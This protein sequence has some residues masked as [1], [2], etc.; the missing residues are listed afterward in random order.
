M[1]Y[2]EE[3]YAPKT[4]VQDFSEPETLVEEP[5]DFA[6]IEDESDISNDLSGTFDEDINLKETL[7]LSEPNIDVA[8]VDEPESLSLSALEDEDDLQSSDAIPE[9][10]QASALFSA[11]IK[12]TPTHESTATA[13]KSIADFLPD[14]KD[15]F[16]SQTQIDDFENEPVLFPDNNEP[17]FAERMDEPKEEVMPSEPAKTKFIDKILGISRARKNRKDTPTNDDRYTEPTVSS[18]SAN[19]DVMDFSSN[20][21]VDMDNLYIPSFFRTKR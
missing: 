19:S 6:P 1:S 18:L 8:S 13:E 20:V 7:E 17:H 4:P 10:P 2:I 12:K 3:S 21:D 9:A 16:S 5:K 15:I 11:L 14:D